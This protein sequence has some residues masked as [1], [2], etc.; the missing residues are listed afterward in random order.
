MER[1]EHAR[2]TP[3]HNGGFG[4]VSP[5]QNGLCPNPI[6]HMPPAGTIGT[7]THRDL[8]KLFSRFT[9]RKNGKPNFNK[10]RMPKRSSSRKSS[11]TRSPAR[12]FRR[13]GTTSS[14][15]VFRKKGNLGDTHSFKGI[16][17]A[18]ILQ[19]TPVGT[20]NYFGGQYIFK[21]TDLPIF[22][23]FSSCFDFVRINKCRMEFMPRYNMQSAPNNAAG[24]TQAFTMTFLTGLDE[25]PF[26]GTNGVPIAAPTWL[27]QGDED[28]AITEATA[29]QNER[30]T[31]DYIRGMQRSKETE[32]Y[33]K[34]SISFFPVFYNV[35]WNPVAGPTIPAGASAVFEANMKKWI[36]INA[37]SSG[38]GTSEVAVPGPDY[39]GPMYAFGNNLP[40]GSTIQFY[41]VKLHYSISFRRLKGF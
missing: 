3:T 2:P 20:P 19:A 9:S 39:Y 29:Y 4:G 27:S 34:H 41:D 6:I 36:N 28:A 8:E 35:L 38:G 24:N 7:A 15:R 18:G 32:V 14:K 33:K 1:S 11:A 16:I 26:S 21:L 10:P 5:P 40:S 31:P 23:N 13:R 22:Q 37:L 25:I 12:A 30:I 17:N